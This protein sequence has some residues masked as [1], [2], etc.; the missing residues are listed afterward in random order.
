MVDFLW[1]IIREHLVR[2]INLSDV[3]VSFR[4]MTVLQFLCWYGLVLFML[5]RWV[6]A[7]AKGAVR[8]IM[9]LFKPARS[10]PKMN[11]LKIVRGFG[12]GIVF[13]AWVLIGVNSTLNMYDRLIAMF[14]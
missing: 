6:I 13:I 5:C 7:L 1:Y 9:R 14:G 3:D 2:Q 12:V 11:T 10:T 4:F 8:V